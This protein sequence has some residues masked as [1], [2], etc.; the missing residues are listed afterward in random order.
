MRPGATPVTNLRSALAELAEVN[1]DGADRVLLSNLPTA[2]L[3]LIVD[4]FEELFVQAPKAEQ[5]AFIVVLKALRTLETVALV[6]TMRADFYPDLMN[7]DLWPV[8]PSQRLEITALRGNALRD[9]IVK[10]AAQLGVTLEASLVERLLAD[11]A[12]EPGVLPLLQETMR[13]LWDAQV[14]RSLP[15]SAYLQLGDKDGRSGLAVAMATK[16]DATL[17]QLPEPQR[18]IARRIFLRLV[19]FGEGRSDTR[20]Q[21]ALLDLRAVSDDQA[22]FAETL[23]TLTDNRLLTLSGDNDADRKVDIAHEMLIVGWPVAQEWVRLRREAEL[24]R[25]RLEVKAGEWARLGRSTGGLLDADELPEAERW[26][27]GADAVDL[28]VSAELAALVQKSREEIERRA[29]EKLQQAQEM[30]RAE[31][32]AAAEAKTAGAMRRRAFWARRGVAHRLPVR[33]R[34]RLAVQ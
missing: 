32:R 17:S 21:Q 15:L 29:A 2:R 34:C 5:S 25:R 1:L 23:R 18:V 6:L 24:T 26:L 8:D 19:Q 9:A 4:Q 11:A 22:L 16:A 12:D 33:R 10:P 31:T 14:R 7:C 30:A 28:G 20:R 27:N 3:L 13:M